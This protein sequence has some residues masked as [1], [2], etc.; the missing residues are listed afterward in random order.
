MKPEVLLL[1][2]IYDFSADLVTL[3]LH[4]AGV[5]YLRINKEHLSEY[6]ISLDPA[7]QS[8]RV[9]VDGG[10]VASTEAL[11]SIWYRQPVFLRNT[12]SRALLLEEQLGRSQWAAFLRAMSVFDT[13]SWMNWPQATYL[14]ECKP[15]QLLAAKRCGLKVPAT[16]VTNDATRISHDFPGAMVVKSLD[17]VLLREG[18]DCLFT[19]ATVATGSDFSDSAVSTAPVMVQQVIEAKTDCRITVVGDQV[20]AVRILANGS[21]VKGDWRTEPRESLEYEGFQLPGEIE[22]ACLGLLRKL[23]LSFGGIDLLETSHGYYFLE[24]NPTGEWGWL[25]NSDRPIDEAIASWLSGS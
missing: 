6:R 11:R 3:R 5:P 1:T 22:G 19:Y 21:P 9:E 13:V 20:F 12:P 25:C 10:E 24:V 16:L 15:Y 18:G 17:T 7:A 4:D 2:S 14:A 23:G 8:L